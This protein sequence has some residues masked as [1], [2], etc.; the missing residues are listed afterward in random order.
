MASLVKGSDFWRVSH[1]VLD[2]ARLVEVY[3][4]V[5]IDVV[6]FVKIPPLFLLLLCLDAVINREPSF[7][8]CT[9]GLDVLLEEG[10]GDEQPD[11][12]EIEALK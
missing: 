11:Q 2:A 8:R 3:K 12:D 1:L 4:R 7:G 9:H 10:N 6:V 5:G